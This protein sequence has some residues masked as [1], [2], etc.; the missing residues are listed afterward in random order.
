L[1][2][3]PDQLTPAIEGLIEEGMASSGVDY[4]A[5]LQFQKT[6]RRVATDWI[7]D[8]IW[9][10]PAAR[11]PAPTPETTGDPCMNSPWSLLGFPTITIPMSLSS[12]GLPLGIQMIAG[13][14]RDLELL[15]FAR[16]VETRLRM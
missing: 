9:V 4:A 6:I 8:T 10:M 12:D 2:S 14:G 13:P 1:K 16:W 15:K 5:A 7:G 3:H 11:G